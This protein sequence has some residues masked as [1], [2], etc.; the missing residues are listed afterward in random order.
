MP[1]DDILGVDGDVWWS[2]YAIPVMLVMGN[3][4][5]IVFDFALTRMAMVYL[6]VFQPKLR[7]LFRFK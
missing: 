5:F 6:K 7:K 2:K 1:L 4:V 3:V